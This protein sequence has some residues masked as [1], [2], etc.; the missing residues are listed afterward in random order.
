[1][2]AISC[3]CPISLGTLLPPGNESGLISQRQKLGPDATI[4]EK[5]LE[6]K[7]KTKGQ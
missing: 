3:D 5:E 7:L 2:T 1:M 4:I 6:T